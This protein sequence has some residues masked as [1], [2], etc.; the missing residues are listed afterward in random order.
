[1]NDLDRILNAPDLTHDEEIFYYTRVSF[2]VEDL[3]FYWN[4]L[5]QIAKYANSPVGLVHSVIKKMIDDGRLEI[6]DGV[7]QK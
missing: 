5:S 2:I 7:I 4:H 1:M 3:T 6:V